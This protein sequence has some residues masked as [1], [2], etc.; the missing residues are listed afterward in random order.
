MRFDNE[1]IEATLVARDNRFRATVQL[2]K[3]Q[4]KAHVANPGRLGELLVPGRPVLLS[5]HKSDKRRTDY[6]LTLVNV[7]GEWVSVDSRLP[8]ELVHE[9]LLGKQVDAFRK[10]A[11]VRR[12]V[13]QGHS[14]FDFQLEG[15]NLPTCWLE[16]KSVTLLRFGLGCFPDAVTARGRRHVEEL[17]LAVANGHR[18]AVLFCVQRRNVAGFCPHDEADPAFG[19]ALREAHRRGVEVYAYRCHID[20]EGA[21]LAEQVSVFLDG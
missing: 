5:E 20:L 12:E 10:Y 15:P 16:V 14:R 13:M 6:D 3:D 19:L 18:A 1:W 21:Q 17:A 8:N 11:V 7:D 4:V 9:A 2:G